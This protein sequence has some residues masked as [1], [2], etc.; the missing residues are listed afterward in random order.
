M[1]SGK[2]HAT[3]SVIIAGGIMALSFW[4]GW[5]KAPALTVGIGSLSGMFLSPDLDQD[6]KT[7]SELVIIRKW[8]IIGHLFFVYWYFYAI[9]I[10]HR[11]WSSH[12][13]V[14]GTL[15]RLLYCVPLFL[16]AGY[17]LRQINVDLEPLVTILLQWGKWFVIGLA[18]SDFMH[19]LR[20]SL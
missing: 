8:P 13:P 4:Q 12:F 19:W 7:R 2:I 17:G 14:V 16:L 5:E 18:L 6:G 9:A 1:P 20:D 15:L 11:H 10:P 3:D